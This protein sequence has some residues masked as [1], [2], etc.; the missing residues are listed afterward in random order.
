VLPIPPYLDI[1]QQDEC[2]WGLECFM[3][4][5][6]IPLAAETNALVVGSAFKDDTMM[7]T[8]AKVADSLDTKYGGIG[9]TPV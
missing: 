1:E 4:D 7:M 6:L 2:E 5:V 3:R 8:F 9:M